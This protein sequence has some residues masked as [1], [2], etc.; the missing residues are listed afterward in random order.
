MNTREKLIELL[1]EAE[2]LVNN[3]VPSLE[4][5]ADHL[6]ANGVTML[7]EPIEMVIPEGF[8]EK[9]LIEMLHNA[10]LQ[11]LPCEPEQEW[12][13]VKDRLPEEKGCYLI[14]CNHWWDGKPV[15]REAFWNGD[16]W[17]SC[18]DKGK[19]TPRTTHWMPLPQPPKGE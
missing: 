4:Q 9:R 10:P 19:I 17:L 5:I 16:D 13:S 14:A 18:Y 6:I 1:E 12:I 3:D 8:D 11:I 2:G 7:V 15:A